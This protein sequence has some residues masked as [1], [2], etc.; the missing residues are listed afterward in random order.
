MPQ[1]FPPTEPPQPPP[2]AAEPHEPTAAEMF[3]MPMTMPDGKLGGGFDAPAMKMAKISPGD[4]A[5][6]REHLRGCAKLPGSVAATDKIK[7]VLR[8]GFK[9]NGSLAG[10]PTLIEASASAKGP[11]LMQSA[12]SALRACQPY[13][14]LPADQYDEW[15]VL[16]LTFTP[17]DFSAE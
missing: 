8:V 10:A 15:R 11:A 6:F 13:A 3:G 1:F 5:A 7:I 12:V 14:M 9:P 2:P 4:T 16:D 17:E